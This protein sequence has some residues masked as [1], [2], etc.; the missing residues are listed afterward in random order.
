MIKIV[1]A[2]TVNETMEAIQNDILSGKLDGADIWQ[3]ITSNTNLNEEMKKP[4]TDKAMAAA[5]AGFLAGIRWGLECIQFDTDDMVE[6]D[7]EQD[8]N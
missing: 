6:V 1:P 7:N 5:L 3:Y 2:K 4:G 8:G